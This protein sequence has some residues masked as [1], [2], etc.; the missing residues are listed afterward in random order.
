MLEWEAV[1]GAVGAS[2]VPVAVAMVTMGVGV[3]AILRLWEGWMLSVGLSLV[4]R[5]S[6]IWLSLYI[7]RVSIGDLNVAGLIS[8]F[9]L[10]RTRIVVTASRV[11]CRSFVCRVWV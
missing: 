3:E 6:S 2:C 10:L 4:V 5:R 8:S 9:L 7:M 11:V 1:V